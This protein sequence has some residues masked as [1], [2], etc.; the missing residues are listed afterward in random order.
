MRTLISFALVAATLA[1]WPLSSQAQWKWRDA[2]GR[3][4]VS[5]R[6]PPQDVPAQNILSRPYAPD[7][8]Q[9]ATPAERGASQA[10]A[11]SAPAVAQGI[12]PEIEARRKKTE[13]DNEA[14]QKDAE[15]KQAA[16]MR[17]NCQRARSHMATLESG[18]RVA[19][20]ND[21]GEREILDDNQRAAEVARTRDIISS[22][23]R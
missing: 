12:D 18:Q 16:T 2:Q 11:K 14:K 19:S 10:V 22:N 9:A 15:A 20:T 6:P 5:D 13:Q 3:V 17:D 21:K 1:T 7:P 4:T 23:C 8:K